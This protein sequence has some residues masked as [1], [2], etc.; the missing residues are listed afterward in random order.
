[1]PLATAG[2]DQSTQINSGNGTSAYE[3]GHETAGA[4]IPHQRLQKPL[5]AD[6]RSWSQ[7]EAGEGGSLAS[8]LWASC[9]LQGLQRGTR[10]L[11]LLPLGRVR[12][13]LLL[14]TR[15]MRVV[16]P[17]KVRCLKAA[18]C[19]WHYCSH[20]SAQP[21]NRQAP[22]ARFAAV[23]ILRDNSWRLIHHLCTSPPNPPV[24]SGSLSSR[25][26]AWAL[27][28]FSPPR[29]TEGWMRSHLERPPS[30][31]H[32]EC[33][34]SLAGDSVVRAQM[35]ML[36]CRLLLELAAR[37]PSLERRPEHSVQ[38]AGG[39]RGRVGYRSP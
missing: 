33:D 35:W 32:V 11:R 37:F 2:A 3:Q 19:D 18:T 15:V 27:P 31:D 17:S 39:S 9:M 23:Q 6:S 13:R 7:V 4:I 25:C 12:P 38:F 26:R 1:M 16:A 21:G 10:P 34:R 20:S 28:K 36:W 24:L 14:V 29:R 30:V 5:E 22:P 8:G